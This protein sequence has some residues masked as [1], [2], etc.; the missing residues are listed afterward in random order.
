MKL[1]ECVPNISEGRNKDVIDKIINN[2]KSNKNIELLDYDIGCI[3][4]VA[5]FFTSRI[6]EGF[7]PNLKILF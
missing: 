4:C 5:L 2:I 3:K 7:V 6:R 1:I